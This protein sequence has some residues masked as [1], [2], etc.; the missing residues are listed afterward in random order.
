MLHVK[1]V[2]CK[3]WFRDIAPELRCFVRK[4]AFILLYCIDIRQRRLNVKMNSD[5]NHIFFFFYKT[6]VEGMWA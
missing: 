5:Y 1:N 4:G 3:E 2:L 6:R